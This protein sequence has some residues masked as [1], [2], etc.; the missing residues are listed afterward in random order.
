MLRTFSRRYPQSYP[1]ILWKTDKRTHHYTSK[2]P[3]NSHPFFL[4][5][6]FKYVAGMQRSEIRE[7]RGPELPGLRFAPSGLRYLDPPEAVG[8]DLAT[9][10]CA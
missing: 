6:L 9:V 7:W 4:K 5:L 2:V 10:T 3:A 1:Q 8:S